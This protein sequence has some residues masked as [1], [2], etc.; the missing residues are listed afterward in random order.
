MY[1]Y[2]LIEKVENANLRMNVDE[3]AFTDRWKNWV[4]KLSSKG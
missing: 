3:R 1:N 4:I 2:T